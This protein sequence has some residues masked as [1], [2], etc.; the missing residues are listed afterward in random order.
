M[1]FHENVHVLQLLVLLGQTPENF[2]YLNPL[3]FEVFQV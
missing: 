3:D 2:L 1:Y